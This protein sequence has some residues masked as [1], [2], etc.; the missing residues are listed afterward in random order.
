MEQLTH[1]ASSVMD[2]EN[3]DNQKSSYIKSKPVIVTCLLAILS[4]MLILTQSVLNWIKNMSTDD[5]IWDR[6]VQIILALQNSS[7]VCQRN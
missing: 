3:A 7:D 4:F 2:H 1:V 5:R 6:A